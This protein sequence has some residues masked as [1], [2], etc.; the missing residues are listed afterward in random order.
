V[1]L[2]ATRSFF[3][4]AE[5]VISGVTGRLN[6]LENGGRTVDDFLYNTPIQCPGVVVKRVFY[7]EHGGFRSDLSWTLDCEMWARAIGLASGLVTTEVLSCYRLTD[8]N[9]SRR[10]MRT[11]ETLHDIK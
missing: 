10:L 11:A 5:S 2:L 3:V 4:D 7:E 6:N 9:E 1:S 8:A